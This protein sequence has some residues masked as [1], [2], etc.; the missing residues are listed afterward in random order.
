LIFH[1]F[2]SPCLQIV[3]KVSLGVSKN[4]FTRRSYRPG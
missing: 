4:L 1:N 3:S 2:L